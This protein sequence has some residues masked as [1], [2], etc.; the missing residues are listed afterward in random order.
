MYMH[1]ASQCLHPINIS[2]ST[3][4]K[5]VCTHI[6]DFCRQLRLTNRQRGAI[7]HSQ[8]RDGTL[9]LRLIQLYQQK[10]SFLGIAYF[11]QKTGLLCTD[12]KQLH[13]YHWTNLTSPVT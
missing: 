13:W 9:T 4:T 11:T 8:S 1:P 10:V 12:K 7:L 2:C 3:A 6:K 5:E